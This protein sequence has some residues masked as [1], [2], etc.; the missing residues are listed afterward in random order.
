MQKVLSSNVETLQDSRQDPQFLAS[1]TTLDNGL[2]II[3]VIKAIGI[4]I[5]ALFTVTTV[6]GNKAGNWLGKQ[7]AQK[8]GE[9]SSHID[10]YLQQN[11]PEEQLKQ[12]SDAIGVLMSELGD[13]PSDL[14]E[15]LADIQDKVDTQ[16]GHCRADGG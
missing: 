8:I 16:R 3:Q 2:W 4:A 13:L 6:T 9:L 10:N 15:E 12:V 11:P 14:L 1:A 5:G 7:A